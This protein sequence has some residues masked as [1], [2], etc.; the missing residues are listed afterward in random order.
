MS[1]AGFE[2]GELGEFGETGEFGELT[3]F[4]ES[5]E[6]ES[7]QFL[8][9]IL[10]TFTG[11]VGSPLSEAEELSLASELLEISNEG[12]LENFLGSLLNKVTSAAG[13]FINSSAGRALGGV[14]KSIAKKALPVVGG[15]LGSFVA[16]GFGTAIG[17]KLGSMAGNLF[18]LPLETMPAEQ[19]EWE[20][21]RRFVRTAASAAH[22]VANAQPRPGVSPNT[23][24]RAAVAR[25][26]RTYAPGLYRQMVQSLRSTTGR[27]GFASAGR[28]ALRGGRVAGQTDRRYA[29]PPAPGRPMFTSGYRGE[30]SDEPWSASGV[31]SDTGPGMSGRWVRRG[32]KIVILGV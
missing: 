15:A 14:L 16:P 7:E 19:A 18:E 25:A 24:A 3:E 30:P 11:E 8:G 20:V 5:G 29:F 26:A 23:V 13:S 31:A 17:S 9:D 22:S 6:G 10:G 4:G 1:E 12:E 21:A 2:F 28:P 27:P 32:R